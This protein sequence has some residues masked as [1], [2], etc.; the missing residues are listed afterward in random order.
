MLAKKNREEDEKL[1]GLSIKEREEVKKLHLRPTGGSFLS[2]VMRL[3]FFTNGELQGKQLFERNRNLED[4]AL[5]EEG[6]VSV[7][8]SQYERTRRPEEEEQER[9]EFSDSD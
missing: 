8:T 3:I 9:L 5:V 2:F 4:E 1:K 7:D 6:D